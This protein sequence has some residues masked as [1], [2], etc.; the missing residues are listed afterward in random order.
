MNK[1]RQNMQRP[2]V[3]DTVH[4]GQCTETT[5]FKLCPKSRE[6]GHKKQLIQRHSESSRMIRGP[7][8][9]ASDALYGPWCGSCTRGIIFE[10]QWA[11]PYLGRAG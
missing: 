2:Q 6:T 8:S 11:V 9:F 10:I 1:A 7:G 5:G 3:G 4:R